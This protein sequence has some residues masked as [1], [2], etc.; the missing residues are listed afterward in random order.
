LYFAVGDVEFPQRNKAVFDKY[1]LLLSYSWVT[2]GVIPGVIFGK[3]AFMQRLMKRK[4]E[5]WYFADTEHVRQVL[6]IPAGNIFISGN[7]AC[8]YGAFVAGVRFFAGYPITPSSE[9]FSMMQKLIPRFGGV[10]YAPEDELASIGMVIGASLCGAKAMTATSGPGFSLMQEELGFAIL[11]EVPLVIIDAMRVGP[12][13]GQ[14]TKPTSAD[15]SAIIHGRHGDCGDAVV[16]LSPSSV[17]ECFFMTVSAFNIAEQFRVP[18]IIALDGYLSQLEEPFTMPRHLWVYDRINDATGTQ[19]GVDGAVSNFLPIGGARPIAYTGVIHDASGTRKSFDTLACYSL[20]SH[21]LKKQ[22][23]ILDDIEKM[24]VYM[25]VRQETYRVADAEYLIVGYGVGSRAVKDAVV[26]LRSDG[27]MAGAIFLK[28]L[29]PLNDEMFAAY[30]HISRIVVAENNTGQMFSLLSRFFP[31][32]RLVSFPK[33]DGEPIRTSELYLSCARLFRADTRPIVSVVHDAACNDAAYK[34]DL[35]AQEKGCES[36]ADYEQEECSDITEQTTYPFCAGCGH[37]T[38]A[39]TLLDALKD[40]GLSVENTIFI[41]GIGCGSIVPTTFNAHLIKTSHGR[42]L[43]AARAVSL[44]CPQHTIIV[45]SGDGDLLNIGGNHLL[46]TI[47]EKKRF[48]MA[49][50]CLDNANYGM[51]G[52]QSSSTTPNNAYDDTDSAQTPFDLK[53]LLYDGCGIDFF[54]RTSVYDRTHLKEMIMRAVSAARNGT[55]AFVQVGSPCTTYFMKNHKES[56]SRAA[57]HSTQGIWR[58]DNNEN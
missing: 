58:R 47:R 14:P 7:T 2:P 20:I 11:N 3:D 41:S 27:I 36:E 39:D 17:T 26:K 24:N 33:Y 50:F 55:L 51:T 37:K 32:E 19:F 29:W 4:Q 9:I 28:T 30:R 56:F 45:I 38:F 23:N 1:A 31:S 10:A 18:V 6:N 57:L 48:P 5:R 54:A 25:P 46:H 52:G 15:I 22:M 40:S 49:C 53:Q 12:S 35:E 16:V 44:L 42:A 13:T 43:N 8:A 21:L 34:K